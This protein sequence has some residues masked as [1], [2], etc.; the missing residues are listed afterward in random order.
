MYSI[1]Y[2]WLRPASIAACKVEVPPTSSTSLG[3]SRWLDPAVPH[4][5]FR[6]GGFLPNIFAHNSPTLDKYWHRYNLRPSNLFPK[7]Y[8]FGTGFFNC[9]WMLHSMESE[10]FR[11]S[12]HSDHQQTKSIW[13]LLTIL[14]CWFVG[15]GRYSQACFIYGLFLCAK[16]GTYGHSLSL[17]C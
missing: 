9:S 7:K 13:R 10:N 16:L 4:F 8:H 6:I 3:V 2:S 11:Y 15:F 12:P 1:V 14:F 17:A 5:A